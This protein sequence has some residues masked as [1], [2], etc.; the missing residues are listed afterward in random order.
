MSFWLG[1]FW[2]GG[3]R[4]WSPTRSSPSSTLCA[5]SLQ[6]PRCPS[7]GP[8]A[9][10][11]F[12][13]SL[14]PAA[15]P[16]PRSFPLSSTE[17]SLPFFSLLLC[18]AL[19]ISITLLPLRPAVPIILPYVAAEASSY[20][21]PVFQK[22]KHRSRY[23]EPGRAHFPEALELNLN[24]GRRGPAINS[25]SCGVPSAC[26]WERQDLEW[27]HRLRS[28][29]PCPCLLSSPLHRAW[30]AEQISSI[31]FMHLCWLPW[32]VTGSVSDQICSPCGLRAPALP[33]SHSL[34]AWCFQMLPV[35]W[36]SQVQAS[37]RRTLRGY[38]G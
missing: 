24:K 9:H 25:A 27:L 1:G 16:S 5:G 36:S 20:S 21:C 34:P 18:N 8:S 37:V 22:Q 30:P 29:Q 3:W 13:L 11:S 15:F 33:F 23:S 31:N 12:Q 7:A 28:P 10:Q 6:C 35:L 19:M 2:Q 14:S 17:A 38:F 4:S 26:R 32:V